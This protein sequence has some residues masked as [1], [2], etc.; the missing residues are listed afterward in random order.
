[1]YQRLT[2]D[3]GSFVRLGDILYASLT[4]SGQRRQVY[5]FRG[6]D[7]T[8]DY[9][10]AKGENIRKVLL[11]TPLDAVKVSSSFGSRM[12]PILGYTRKHRGVDF[13]APAGT[14]VF[15]AGAGTIVSRGPHAGYGNYIRIHHDKQYD[16]A[17]GHLQSFAKGLKVGDKVRQGQVIGYVGSTGLATGP[18][19]HYELM[20]N[21]QQVNPL[22]VKFAGGR[23]L[24]IR[25]LRDFVAARANIDRWLTALPATTTTARR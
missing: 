20:A 18:H 8:A 23:S 16:T 5:R 7:G 17:Y 24:T 9:Y 11:R 15:A 2:D 12:H 4:L 14:P 21:N 19:L 22:G 1:L 6:A 13:A 10:D 25:E 3:D